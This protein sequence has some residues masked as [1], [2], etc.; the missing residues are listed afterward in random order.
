MREMFSDMPFMYGMVAVVV[1]V[2]VSFVSVVVVGRDL[3]HNQLKRLPAEVSS[4]LTVLKRL[5]LSYNQLEELPS[6]AFFENYNLEELD[7]SYNQLEELP[8]KAFFENYNLEELFLNNNNIKN[9][10]SNQLPRISLGGKKLRNLDLSHNQLKDLPPE[11]F[12][13]FTYLLKMNVTHGRQRFKERV[14]AKHIE[15]GYS[16]VIAEAL[17]R[18]AIVSALRKIAKEKAKAAE[19]LTKVAMLEQRQELEKKAERLRLEEQLAVAQVR[20]RVFAEIENG[21]KEDLSH[22]PAGNAS[23]ALRVPEFSQPGPSFPAVTSLYTDRSATLNTITNVNFTAGLHVDTPMVLTPLQPTRHPTK[24][25][26]LA[27]EFHVADLQPNTQFCDILQEQTRLTELLAEQQQQSFLSSPTLANFTGDLLEST[28]VRSTFV[29]SFESQVEARVSAND[30]RLQYL[31]QYLQGEPKELIKGCLDLDRNSGHIEAKRL[32]REKYGDPYKTLNAYIKEINEWPYIR[33]GDELALHR[34]SIFLGQRQSA[35]STLTY[36][37]ILDHPHNLQSMVS[38][39]PFT[40]QDQW[41]RE[42][43]K[44][45]LARGTTP[46]SDDFVSFVSTEA[47]IATDPIFSRG[48]LRRVDCLSD[49]PDRSNIGKGPAK[50]KTYGDC[51]R[52]SHH[53]SNH[54]TGVTAHHKIDSQNKVR[55]IV[56]PR[57][58]NRMFELDLSEGTDDKEQGYS[59]EDKVFLKIFTQGTRR[60]E[61][62]HY[63]IPLQFR[64][65]DVRFPENKEQVIQRAAD[66]AEK[67]V[68]P[69]TA[70]VL[71]KNFYVDDCFRTEET[72]ESA[73][74][75][76]RGVR[77]ACAHGGPNFLWQPESEWPQP[78]S[79]LDD[80]S[81]NDPEVKKVLVHSMNVEETADLLKRLAHFSE[82]HHMKRSIAWILHLKPNSNDRALLPKDRQDKVGRT[83]RVKCEPLRVEE[84]D[85]AEKTI[86]NLVQSS[87]F[88][89]EIEALQRVRR[90]DCEND[91]QFARKMKSEIK[92]SGTLYR[93]DPFSDQDGLVRV[94]GRL[95]KSQEFSEHFKHPVVLPKKSF[96]VDLIVR[97]AHKKVPMQ[98]VAL[99]CAS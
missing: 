3:S 86:L 22:K 69:E 49:R 59:Q 68:G 17:I 27:H 56:T 64:C 54:A 98:A 99:R 75:R 63:E 7:L 38:K 4:S 53:V 95:S 51:T 24:L 61:E 42:A 32:L 10:S 77:H 88:P 66:D 93:L 9:L 71:R 5:D 97:D 25:N 37:S 58:L 19:L 82:W 43:N 76:I 70:N 14:S 84:P 96:I 6:K 91:R 30:V 18:F 46:T 28:F 31:E 67:I 65:D 94:G 87:A 40:L 62:S 12:S 81:N 34:L 48:A 85:R 55:E 1:G 79:D 13:R 39:L 23:E 45:R 80:V 52:A 33:S 20:E 26:P 83:A 57:A 21:A 47:S 89:K 16:D 90:V 29:R 72:R 36:L 11:A 73:I 60:T 44:K 41:R 35:M 92:K 2:A 8:S 15:H 50:P 78:P 74:Q